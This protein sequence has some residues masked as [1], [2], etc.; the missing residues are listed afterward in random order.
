MQYVDRCV[1]EPD[2]YTN[3]VLQSIGWPSGDGDLLLK[4]LIVCV[5]LRVAMTRFPAVRLL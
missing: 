4:K 3:F 1:Q 5:R 2:C